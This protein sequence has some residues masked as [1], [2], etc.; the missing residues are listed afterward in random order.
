MYLIC[1]HIQKYLLL[2]S[3]PSKT[4]TDKLNLIKNIFK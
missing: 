2:L 4:N 3:D 1:S